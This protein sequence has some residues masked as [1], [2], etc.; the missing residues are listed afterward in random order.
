MKNNFFN[1]LVITCSY[2]P[3][4]ILRNLEIFT[5]KLSSVFFSSRKKKNFKSKILF[6]NISIILNLKKN[7]DQAH[8]VY[9]AL[10][11]NKNLV[12][13]LPLISS[14]IEIINKTGLKNFLD[15]GA[16]MGYYSILLSK[17][18]KN[19]FLNIYAIE[20]NPEYCDIIKQNISENNSLNIKLINAALSNN[21]DEDLFIYKESIKTK[22]CNS[23]LLKIKSKTLDSI[24]FNYSIKPEILKIDVHGFEGRVLNGFKENLSTSVKVIFLELHSQEYLQEYSGCTKKEIINF[25]INNKFNCYILP[26]SEKL[27]LYHILDNFDLL[28]Y[29]NSYR[30]INEANYNDLFFDKEN[31][32]NLVIAFDKS[33]S[34][35]NFNCFH[36]L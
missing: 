31:K 30:K 13:E 35:E 16:F 19:N 20:S 8:D 25:L 12:Y 29:K 11:K 6:E 15:V 22:K 18:F 3:D 36:H 23:N 27:N 1:F 5:K 34:I 2:A 17:F 14:I 28:N 26:Y 4:F 33:I 7:D 10:N 9:R 24:C 21:A 32:D